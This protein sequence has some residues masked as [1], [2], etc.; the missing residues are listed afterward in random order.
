MDKL[1]VAFATDDRKNFTKEHFGEAKEYLVYKIS[2]TDFYLIDTIENKSP[3]EKMHGDPKKAKGVA[4]ILKP[5]GVTVL[6]TKA[7]GQNIV[8]QQ[9]KFVCILSNTE[10]IEEAI[11]NIQLNFDNIIAEWQK[12]ESRG[13]LRI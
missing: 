1:I 2:K 5:L 4:S 12:G 8:R 9:Q 7:F 11:K 13:Y 6:I 3:E 10:L